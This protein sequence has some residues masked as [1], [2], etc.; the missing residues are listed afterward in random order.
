MSRD[1]I[2]EALKRDR[3]TL[4]RFGVRSIALF[5]STARDEAR[6]SSDVDILVEYH[7]DARPDLVD[8]M[9]LKEHLEGLLGRPV[10]LTTPEGL[11][12]RLRRRILSEAVY[13]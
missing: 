13:A 6:S 5:G 12:H 7:D 1:D 9:D 8:F 2:L 10:D 4:D 3:P 11:H